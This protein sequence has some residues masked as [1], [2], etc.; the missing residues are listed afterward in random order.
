MPFGPTTPAE[1]EVALWEA[2]AHLQTLIRI[3]TV[4]PPGNELAVARYLDDV[5]RGAGIN[6]I[7]R[8][9]S[10]G[11]GAVVARVWGNG[12][13]RPVMLLAHMDV[14]GVERDRWTQQPFG[15]EI[16]EGHI[17]GRGAIDDK[18]MLATNLQTLLLLQRHCA[19]GGK[20]LNRDVILV[21]TSDE[22]AG[23]ALGIEWVL[24]HVPAIRDAE[25]ALNE[26][27]R[28]RVVNERPLYCAVQCAEKVA[29]NVT[30]VARGTGGHAA[31]PHDDNAIGRL[32]RALTV[33]ARHQEPVVL[34]DVTTA[35]FEGLAAVWPDAAVAKAMRDLTSGE[36]T[37]VQRGASRL[38][39]VPSFNAAIRS[40]ISPT[41]LTA[42]VRSNVIPTDATANLNVRTMPGEDIHLLIERILASVADPQVTA[43]VR[44]SGRS[45]G[46]SPIGSPMFAAI[47]DSVTALEPSLPTLPYLSAGATDSAA[48]REAGVQCYG[49]LPFPLTQ[50]DEDRMHDHDERVGVEALGFGLKLTV[51]IVSRVGGASTPPA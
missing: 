12:A 51:G 40:C 32:A 44:S 38:A 29:H 7:L 1:W 27:G 30:L 22:E 9:P 36:P 28:I 13:E 11:R 35:F 8:E 37:R 19:D 48:L 26:G 42:G 47:R 25:F 14:V 17:Y 23:G 6:S 39:R 4:N 18:G 24:E 49:L 41:K 10:P 16:V 46:S 45:G 34:T 31:T 20:R 2:V 33:V 21:A 50:E 5:L 3:D 43:T 15:G